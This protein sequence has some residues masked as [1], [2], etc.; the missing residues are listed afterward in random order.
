MKENEKNKLIDL[1]IIAVENASPRF[2]FC[3]LL[4]QD[5]EM[6]NLIEKY[7]LTKL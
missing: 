5:E 6:F 2:L 3:D 4:E 7:K 1:L